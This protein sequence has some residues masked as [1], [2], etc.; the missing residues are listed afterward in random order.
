MEAGLI[1]YEYDKD[2]EEEKKSEAGLL[3][4]VVQLWAIIR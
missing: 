3:P 4:V 1:D 2:S